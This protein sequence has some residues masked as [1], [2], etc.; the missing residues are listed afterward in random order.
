M[1]QKTRWWRTLAGSSAKVVLTIVLLLGFV[2]ALPFWLRSTMEDRQ[3]LRQIPA[4]AHLI[5]D[6]ALPWEGMKEE[7]KTILRDMLRAP[8]LRQLPRHRHWR[9]TREAGIRR[10]ISR[11]VKNEDEAQEIAYWTYHYCKR[12]DLPIELVLALISVESNFDHFAVSRVGARGLMQV[13]PFW[14]E[15]LGSEKDNLFVIETNIRYGCAILRYYLDRYRSRRRALQA[16][17]GS[18]GSNRYSNKVL[19]RMRMFRDISPRA[20][21]HRK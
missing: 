1:I 5:H 15:K 14:K 3:H 4:M 21:D 7:E 10:A 11:W 19:A 17:N 12:F 9:N 20:A 13:M 6:Q 2:S 8:E 16:Y 18:L